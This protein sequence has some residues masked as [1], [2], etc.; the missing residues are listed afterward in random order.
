MATGHQR[1][2]G[3]VNQTLYLQSRSKKLEE[4]LP[5]R[6]IDGTGVLRGVSVYIDGYISATTDIEM[7]KLVALAGGEI[8]SVP[9]S[10]CF[11][12]LSFIVLLGIR[13]L[14][15]HIS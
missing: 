1:S 5:E 9:V 3:R 2:D 10:F 15:Q 12:S 8:S 6:R 11:P 4:Q 13:H 7:K 14:E